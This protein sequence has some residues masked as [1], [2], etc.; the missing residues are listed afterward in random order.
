MLLIRRVIQF[1]LVSLSMSLLSFLNESQ[2]FSIWVWFPA[3][4]KEHAY[5]LFASSELKRL[6]LHYGLW[7]PLSSQYLDCI[8]SCFISNSKV[9]NVC[10]VLGVRISELDPVSQSIT[11]RSQQKVLEPSKIVRTNLVSF[12]GVPI[13]SHADSWRRKP[14]NQHGFHSAITSCFHSERSQIN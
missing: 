10:A 12:T 6:C 13:Q 5:L 8:V 11:A 7:R 4:A 9:S 3:D 14:S 2:V 1:L